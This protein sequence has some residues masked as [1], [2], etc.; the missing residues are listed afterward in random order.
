MKMKMMNVIIIIIMSSSQSLFMS[1]AAASSSELFRSAYIILHFGFAI[2]AALY[3]ITK[4]TL[5]CQN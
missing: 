2:V 1:P 4:N 5:T 3:E